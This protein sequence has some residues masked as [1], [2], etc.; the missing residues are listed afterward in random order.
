M[1]KGYT[2]LK[3]EIAKKGITQIEIATTLNIHPNTVTNK[4]N[5]E[6][7]FSIEEA[8]EIKRCFFPEMDLSYLFKSENQTIGR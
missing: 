3:G 5:G 7:S 2:N 6:S 8:F 1:S 4:I